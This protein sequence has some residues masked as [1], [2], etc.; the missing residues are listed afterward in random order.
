MNVNQ[1]LGLEG[2]KDRVGSFWT[3]PNSGYI[4]K[5][6][7]N[8]KFATLTVLEQ[9]MLT[10][11]EAFVLRSGESIMNKFTQLEDRFCT[12]NVFYLITDSLYIHNTEQQKPNEKNFG[13]FLG[14]KEN[15]MAMQEFST[16]SANNRKRS[17]VW[18]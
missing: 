9:D 10:N 14:E 5:T 17:Y 7:E 12:D 16:V 1:R 13:K 4:L 6:I 11:L 15:C 18:Q 2:E 8:E 3:F